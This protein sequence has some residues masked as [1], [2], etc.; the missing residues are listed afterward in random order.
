MRAYQLLILSPLLMAASCERKPDI[1]L[2]VGG[3]PVHTVT[4]VVRY[5]PIDKALTKPC[6]VEPS[7]ALSDAPL[8]AAKRKASLESCNAQLESIEAV[9]GTPVNHGRGPTK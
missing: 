3:P 7:G 1:D 9:Q 4:E 6:P 5:V 2:P 8:V